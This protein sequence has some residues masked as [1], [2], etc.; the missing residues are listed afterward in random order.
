ML[1]YI[2]ILFLSFTNCSKASSDKGQ[3]TIRILFVGN[4]LTYT[5][6]LPAIV[7]EFGMQDNITI[8]Y[9]EMLVPNYSFE[10]HWNDG[11]IQVEIESKKYDYVIAQQ[12]PSALQ[13]SQVLL[14]D[15]ATR[16]AN[17][18]KANNTK[19]ALYMVWPSA[20]RSFDLDNVIF[21][22]TQAATQ[23]SSLLCPAGLAWKHAWQ[24]DAQLP[25]YGADGFHPSVT[26]SVLAALTIYGVLKDKNN[27]EFINYSNVS[28][29]NEMTAA[30]YKTLKQAALK[31]LG[32]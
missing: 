21:S 8:T 12:G 7:K 30:Q 15:Y 16:I 29:K 32:K 14:L 1:K 28:W 19:F 3:S 24:A 20:S 5:N 18:C 6:N 27:F 13:A 11:K 9:S 17:V 23:T 10:D 22:Y 4:S 26:G 25:L 31:A 2:I